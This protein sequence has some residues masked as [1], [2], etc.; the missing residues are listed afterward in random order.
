MFH[1]S[2]TV[3][4]FG[5]VM[6]KDDPRSTGR[7]LE[8]LSSRI[9]GGED[10]RKWLVQEVA[11][12]GYDRRG[13]RSLIFSTDDLMRRVQRY[14]SDWLSLSDEELLAISLRPHR[15]AHRRPGEE[16]S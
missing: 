9:V 7:G 1:S 8:L 15:P 3:A 4:G 16:S 12:W 2:L 10:G 5:S 11:D 6:A 13:S 14:P